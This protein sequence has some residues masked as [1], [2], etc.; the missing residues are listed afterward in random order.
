ME[1]WPLSTYQVI[2][3]YVVMILLT[4]FGIIWWFSHYGPDHDYKLWVKDNFFRWLMSLMWPM[5]YVMLICFAIAAGFIWVYKRTI[6][7]VE[8]LLDGKA[9][10]EHLHN[11]EAPS[12]K[13]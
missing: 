3:T 9:Q 6:G 1:D 11:G 4:D 12:P 8:S 2:G 7:R 13:P 5:F 10:N